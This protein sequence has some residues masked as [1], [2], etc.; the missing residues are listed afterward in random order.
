RRDGQ[1]VAD[2]ALAWL[3]Q[4]TSRPFFC[5]IHLYDAHAPYKPRP[6]TYQQRFVQ[7][8]YDAGVAWEIQQFERL[9]SFL[10]E[11]Q[12]DSNT[13]VVVAGDHGEGLDE[14]LEVEHGMLVYNTTL[15]VPFVFVGPR[16]CQPGTRVFEPV[17]LVDLT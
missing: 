14:H 1:E 3:R 16:D 2:L 17:S 11:R 9:T 15:H 6:E 5:W 10:A 13:V 12:L 8:P 4:R 7:N